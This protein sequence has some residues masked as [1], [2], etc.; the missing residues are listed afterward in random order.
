MQKENTDSI[1]L[2]LLKEFEKKQK[3][4]EDHI[5]KEIEDYNKKKEEI[6]EEYVKA[7]RESCCF[8][9]AS[10]SCKGL[11]ARPWQAI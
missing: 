3:E 6:R 2:T 1:E 10:F 4:L 5:C 7:L 11:S 9:C 8:L